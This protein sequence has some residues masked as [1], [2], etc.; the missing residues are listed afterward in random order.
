MA[1]NGGFHL[2]SG[3]PM[4]LEYLEARVVQSSGA[5]GARPSVHAARPF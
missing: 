1:L 2:K 3:F 4:A 5:L